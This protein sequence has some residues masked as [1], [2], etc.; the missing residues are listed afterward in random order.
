MLEH[1]QAVLVRVEEVRGL[2]G[3]PHR[4]IDLRRDHG[5][6]GRR[7]R[8]GGADKAEREPEGLGEGDD[9]TKR[10][11]AVDRL[12]VAAGGALGGRERGDDFSRIDAEVEGT[13]IGEEVGEKSASGVQYMRS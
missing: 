1:V 11:V 6:A 2:D 12:G 5:A 10:G 4:P 13:F 3:L 8:A 9:V 7:G